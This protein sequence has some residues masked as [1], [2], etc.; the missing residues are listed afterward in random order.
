M[1]QYDYCY[2]NLNS[3]DPA[4]MGEAVAFLHT[5][6]AK[7]SG[8]MLTDFDECQP[9]LG[10]DIR[11]PISELDRD[12]SRTKLKLLIERVKADTLGENRVRYENLAGVLL[13]FTQGE[14]RRFSL[15]HLGLDLDSRVGLTAGNE[16]RVSEILAEHPGEKRRDL[17]C[18]LL[19]EFPGLSNELAVERPPVGRNPPGE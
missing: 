11:L 2:F 3:R 10:G 8:S 15:E 18:A 17:V 4:H 7:L 13:K 6:V 1:P 19:A 9:Q 12:V 16:A 5:Y 14:L